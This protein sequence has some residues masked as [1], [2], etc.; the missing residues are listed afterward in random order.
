MYASK[1][2]THN[3]TEIRQDSHMTKKTHKKKKIQ[4]D[5]Q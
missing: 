5:L 1:L 3:A 4:K 2:A